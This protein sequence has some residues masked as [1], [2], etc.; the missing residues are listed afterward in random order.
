MSKDVTA[1][2]TTVLIRETVKQGK[3]TLTRKIQWRYCA[4]FADICLLVLE[5]D[6]ISVTNFFFNSLDVP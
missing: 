4:S 1:Y 6:F 5:L 3:G 2:P